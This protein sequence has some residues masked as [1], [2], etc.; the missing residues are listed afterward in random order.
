MFKTVIKGDIKNQNCPCDSGICPEENNEEERL[1]CGCVGD[2]KCHEDSNLNMAKSEVYNILN[3]AKDLME[4]LQK[5]D[6]IEA[7]MLAKLVNASDYMCSVTGVLE[8]ADYEQNMKRCVDDV[9]KDIKIVSQFLT[10][11]FYWPTNVS[12]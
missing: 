7:W 9:S 4:L 3:Y 12:S 2:C 11:G 8:Y 6:T 5:V 10:T 1:N